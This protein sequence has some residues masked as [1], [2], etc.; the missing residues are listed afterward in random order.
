MGINESSDLQLDLKL[1][2]TGQHV[3]G[4]YDIALICN[5]YHIPW[6]GISWSYPLAL[7]YGLYTVYPVFDTCTSLVVGK[8]NIVVCTAACTTA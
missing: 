5:M 1:Y 6:E 2:W 7:S 4:K 8:S 3:R